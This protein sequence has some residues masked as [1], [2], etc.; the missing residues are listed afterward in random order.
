MSTIFFD[1]SLAALAKI[2]VE[3]LGEDV[4][5]RGVVLRDASG[6]LTFVSRDPAPSERARAE[7]AASVS[8]SLGAYARTDRPVAFADDPGAMRLLDDVGPLFIKVGE[9]QCRVIDRR[10]VGSAAGAPRVVFA[11]LK[12]GVGRSTALAITAS[13][14]ANRGRNVLAVDL[15]LEAPGI[16]EFLLTE[17][18]MPRFGVVDYL[19]ENGIG[20]IPNNQIGRAH[21]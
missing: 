3:Q 4:L 21:V 9:Y 10:I 6:L 11:S 12:G 1:D 17:E 2:I 15:D 16:G 7:I 20:G 8:R 19:V 14:L 13:D 5:K 18:R